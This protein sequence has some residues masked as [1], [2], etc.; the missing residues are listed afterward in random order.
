MVVDHSWDW[1]FLDWWP[2]L[3]SIE[4]WSHFLIRDVWIPNYLPL[5]GIDHIQ[6]FKL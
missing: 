6:N 5:E 4:W 3:F 1:F 2:L